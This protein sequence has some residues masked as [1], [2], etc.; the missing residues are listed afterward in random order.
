MRT[1]SNTLNSSLKKNILA[2]VKN[3]EDPK[4]GNIQCYFY[5]KSVRNGEK[6]EEIYLIQN[7]SENQAGQ[8]AS[9]KGRAT[10]CSKTRSVVVIITILFVSYFVYSF[11]FANEYDRY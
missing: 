7:L 3:T 1:L 8:L 9:L 5:K 4:V 11:F 10:V 2:N 6:S